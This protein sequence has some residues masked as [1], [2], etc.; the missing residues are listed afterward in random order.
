MTDS[1]AKNYVIS[2]GPDWYIPSIDELALLYYNR[3]SAQKGLRA[4]GYTSLT[5]TGVGGEN[6][7]WSSTEGFGPYY[8][9]AYF[10]DF[11][12]GTSYIDFKTNGAW[13]V[14]GIKSF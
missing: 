2:L 1:P 5:Q 10:F 3:Y 13:V 11:V 7:Y 6:Y 9:F 12:R 14:R 4:G 8:N